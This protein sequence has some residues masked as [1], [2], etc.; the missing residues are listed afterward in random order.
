MSLVRSWLFPSTTTISWNGDATVR[1]N[2]RSSPRSSLSVGMTM[3]TRITGPYFGKEGGAVL[4]MKKMTSAIVPQNSTCLCQ[5][6]T[7]P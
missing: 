3:L 6:S 4:N 7:S 5:K 2:V 1:L